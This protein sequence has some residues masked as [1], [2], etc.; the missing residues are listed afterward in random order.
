MI[1]SFFAKSKPLATERQTRHAGAIG[2]RAIHKLRSFAGEGPEILY[3][4]IDLLGR[5][6]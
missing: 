2:V 4:H 5:G 3:N 1:I 6:P